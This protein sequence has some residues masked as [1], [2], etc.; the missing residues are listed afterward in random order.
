MKASQ[1]D[2]YGGIGDVVVRDIARPRPG[3]GQAL[4]KIAFAAVNPL[5]LLNL[6]GAVKL[7]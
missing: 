5:D 3:R 4:V 2:R 6:T 1:I 7:V